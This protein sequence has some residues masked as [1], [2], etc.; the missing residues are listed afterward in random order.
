MD[1]ARA[2]TVNGTG[3]TTFSG[4]VGGTTALSS[5]TSDAGGTLSLKSVTTSGAQS[6]GEALT[7]NGTYIAGSGA[8][9]ASG[10]TTLDGA[11]TITAAG[12]SFAGTVNGTQ[13]LSLSSGAG[14][15]DLAGAVGDTTRLGGLAL[16]GSGTTTIAG[17]V[18]AA[19]VTT[20]TSGGT[21]LRGGSVDTTGAQDYAEAVTLGADTT[22]SGT[23]V[24]LSAGADAATAGT[25]GLTI[26]GNAALTGS[27]GATAALKSLAISGA[28]TLG[29]GAI[30]TTGSQ[31]YGGTVTLR[32][33]AQTLTSGTSHAM[34]F[35]G[36]LD[37]AQALTIGSATG[38]VT[39]AGA[40]GGTERIG[41][42]TVNTGGA[43]VFDALVRAG[44]VITDVAGTLA[45]NGGIIDTTGTQSY[46]EL[47]F[48]GTDTT[49]SG[50]AVTLSGGADATVAGGQG[51]T[52]AGTLT[53]NAALGGN[54]ALSALTVTGNSSLLSVTTS[55]AQSHTGSATLNGTY[56]TGNAAFGVTGA[57]TLAGATTVSTGTGSISFGGTVDGAQA[58]T[59]NGTGATTFSGAVGATTAL[60]SLTSDAG[61]TLGLKSVTTSGAQSYGETATLDGAY[62]TGNAAF[63]VTGAATLA[64]GTTINAGTG[65]ISFGGTVDGARALTVNGTGTTTFSGAVGAT[66]ALS[67]LTS[68]TGGT[69]GIGSVT[70]A[71]A[72]SYGEDVT[73]SGAAYTT[74]NGAFSVG[75]STALAT[76]VTIDAGTGA[77]SF[78]GTVDG[79]RAL[80]VNGTGATTFSGAV[81]ATTALSSLTSDAGGTLS[82]KSVTT[83]GAQSYGEPR[84]WTALHDRQRRVR[85]HRGGDAGRCHHGQHGHRLDQLRRHGGRRAGA[86]RQRHRRQHLRRR[87]RRHD[88]A[89]QP[90]QRRRRHAQPEVG[91][92]I[93]RAE[94]RR[95]RDARRRLHDRQRRL[96]RHR[97]GDAGRCHHRQRR[98]HRVRLD[99]G[100]RPLADGGQPDGRHRLRRRGRRHR[101]SRRA[102]G[103]RWRRHHPARHG[104]GRLADHRHQRTHRSERRLGGYDRRA[105][106][107]RHCQVGCGHGA[108]RRHGL[109]GR[110]G[111]RGLGGRT[112]TDHRWQRR[113]DQRLRRRP[114]AED[115]HRQRRHGAERRVDLDRRDADLRGRRHPREPR[116]NPDQRRRRN[117]FASILDGGQALALSAGAGNVTFAGAV[118]GGVRLGALTLDTGG[119]TRFAG[120]VR[121]ESVTTDSA[122]TLALDGGLIDT[123]GGQSYGELAVLGADTVL[124]GG[125]ITLG[126]GADSSDQGA[127]TLT[128]TGDAVV[129]GA[130]GANRA[131][132]GLTVTGA[133][134]LNGGTVATLADQ[135]FGGAVQLGAD[136]TLTG[137]VITLQGGGD[138]VMAGASGLTIAGDAVLA[139]A[140]GSARE[141]K[142]FSVSGATRLIGDS[143]LATA[144]GDLMFGGT[145][146]TANR[147]SLSLAA[148]GGSIHAVGDIGGS[149][150]LGD[151]SIRAGGGV[152]FDGAVAARSVVQTVGG[153][154]TRFSKG[155]TADGADGISLT[156]AS[157]TFDAP[158]TASAG[159]LAIT[160]FDSSGA[161]TFGV[162]ANIIT[163]KGL[164]QKEGSGIVLPGFITNTEGPIT[165]GAVA[166]LP[167]GDA[168]ITTDGDIT[169]AGLQGVGTMLTMASRNG[170]ALVIG[171]Q[172]GDAMRKIDVLGLKV[173]TAGSARM[174]GAVAGKTDALAASVIDSPL[175]AAP[176]FIN[177]TPWGPT[178]SVSR[179]VS[180]VIVEFR[181]PVRRASTA[182]LPAP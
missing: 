31:G 53:A 111:G 159:A 121:A 120:T 60:S 34:T 161:V 89:F 44:S 153:A 15:I 24:T 179:I 70:T 115:A 141:L 26:A 19:S 162:G 88:G 35:S 45:L 104:Q 160:G 113:A 48:L 33:A 156:G 40:V 55:G 32:T 74:G 182:C 2:L 37:G 3:A 12:I 49:L 138:S 41:A 16:S 92:N 139:G 22:L 106:L 72:Q 123:S 87:R 43:T 149:S 105:K 169:M 25:Q 127:R 79:A 128:I 13:A 132:R 86:D 93:G 165:L 66:T 148:I 181:C 84:R 150:P 17:A 173:P 171:S 90:D 54:R 107:W 175:R 174:Y 5:L 58:L 103:Q 147:T 163:A 18:R 50:S 110:R 114:G 38:A 101:P 80:T 59:V 130:V 78:G 82:L 98:R 52:V 73:L 157:F 36:T 91:D 47:A 28:A 168:S 143:V 20:D 158:V 39:F 65:P 178:Q 30:V 14:T 96:R 77:I 177:N 124:S 63:G 46:G 42:L 176:Y 11:A 125:A 154:T 83:S 95:N 119:A 131:L 112:R 180:T 164:T 126:A 155:L 8:F 109:T 68:D 102:H 4:A 135:S 151:I 129:N 134:A 144:G 51:L 9:T 69:L 29:G 152:L 10:N 167:S 23:T 140:F 170:G 166:T 146:D 56:T 85:R 71:G 145:I 118:G 76:D 27:F 97:G 21:V 94:L 137:G 100:R 62:T 108:D 116:R 61:G 1:G 81:G 142:H 117:F 136:T 7:L 64:G 122:G 67:S 57:A 99:A 75:G 6:Y 172:D 133:S